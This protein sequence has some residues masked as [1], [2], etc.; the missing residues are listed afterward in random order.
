MQ[1]TLKGRASCCL[2]LSLALTLTITMAARGRSVASP[3]IA[4]AARESVITTNVKLVHDCGNAVRRQ[5]GKDD[6]H[7]LASEGVRDCYVNTPREG[8]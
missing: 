5:G 6:Q 3:I 2:T 7:S 4:L 8:L 1:E